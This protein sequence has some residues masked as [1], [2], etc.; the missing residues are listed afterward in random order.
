MGHKVHPTGMRLGLV[1]TWRSRWYADKKLYGKYLVE[2]EKIRV[3]VKKN[4]TF[5]GIPKIEIER[6]RDDVK[7]ILNTARPG[8]IIGRKGSEV[9]RLR[10]ELESITGRQVA[11]DIRDVTKPEISAQLIAEGIGEQLIKR[12][13]VRRSIKRAGES[14]MQAGALGIKV[15][16]SGRIGGAEMSRRERMV[17]GSIP[18]HTLQAKVD[19]GLA[20]AT[21]KAGQIGIKVWVYTGLER[22]TERKISNAS[23]AQKGEVP[24]VP[25]RQAQG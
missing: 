12:G 5:A 17:L 18:L 4:Y 7:V 20:E 21:T 15:I 16:V 19:Y 2:D 9:D 1:E 11:V 23:D 3:F 25:A 8:V 14:A 22:N 10:T 24:E 13:A 6:T